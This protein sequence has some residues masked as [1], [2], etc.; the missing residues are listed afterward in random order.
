MNKDEL[1]RRNRDLEKIIRLQEERNQDLRRLLDLKE[2]Q[3]QIRT[4]YQRD[5]H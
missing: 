5:Y 2:K 3:L 1:I 4:G